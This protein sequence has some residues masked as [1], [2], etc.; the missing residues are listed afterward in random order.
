MLNT[1]RKVILKQ[2]LVA[3]LASLFVI[4]IYHLIIPASSI[5][6]FEPGTRDYSNGDAN[7]ILALRYLTHLLTFL[8]VGGGAAWL[9]SLAS[10]WPA[11]DR[12]PWIRIKIII[13]LGMVMLGVAAIY[14][15]EY[16]WIMH[17]LRAL[18]I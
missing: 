14:L 3:V 4:Q 16:A 11:K 7:R 8:L 13:A 17:A 10:Q 12:T 18:D 6:H 1:S 9:V 5:F 2:L 15:H